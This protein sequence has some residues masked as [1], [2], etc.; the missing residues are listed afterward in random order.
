M[1]DVLPFTPRPQ[2]TD[3]T[4]DA[5]IVERERER[6]LPA[7]AATVLEELDWERLLRGDVE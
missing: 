6:E 5:E 7:L 4:L 2:Q 1:A 3:A